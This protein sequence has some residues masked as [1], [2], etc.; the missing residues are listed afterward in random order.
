MSPSLLSTSV[1]PAN[2]FPSPKE[3][4]ST[5]AHSSPKGL[6]G[7]PLGPSSTPGLSAPK[8]LFS[9]PLQL[10][11]TQ[12]LSPSNGFCCP[13][14]ASSPNGFEGSSVSVALAFSATS[15]FA[16][17]S[18]GNA[19]SLALVSSTSCKFASLSGDTGHW[20]A[21]A[22]AWFA[23]STFPTANG[24]SSAL[25]CFTSASCFASAFTNSSR[26]GK[27]FLTRLSKTSM[28]VESS[29]LN[30]EKSYCWSFSCIMRGSGKSPMVISFSWQ[31]S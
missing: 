25:I 26:A 4:S 21:Y 30:F 10:S 19:N 13:S 28:T 14:E 16:T 15:M 1:S 27:S 12:G 18:V 31:I 9:C 3:F 7:C 20:D 8:G 22:E 29:F 17:S 24:D 23:P 2:G 6:F 5:Q 11:S